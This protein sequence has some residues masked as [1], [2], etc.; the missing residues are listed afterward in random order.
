MATVQ[1]QAT[2]WIKQAL[3]F[4]AS[5]EAEIIALVPAIPLKKL[6]MKAGKSG[7]SAYFILLSLVISAFFHGDSASLRSGFTRL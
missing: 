7:Y 6:P 1:E 5:F 4:D 3:H 2:L